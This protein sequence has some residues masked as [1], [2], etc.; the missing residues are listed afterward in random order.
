MSRESRWFVLAL[1]VS[2]DGISYST[3]IDD[4]PVRLIVMIAGPL[5]SKAGYLKLLSTLMRFI[6]SEKGKILSSQSA[7]EIRRF[8]SR[9]ALDLPSADDGAQS[10]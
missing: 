5:S 8:A 6:K 9:Y 1:G 2:E 7:A 10:E 3:L 4:K